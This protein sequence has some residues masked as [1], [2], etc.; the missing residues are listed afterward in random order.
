MTPPARVVPRRGPHF[1]ERRLGLA[2]VAEIKNSGSAEKR[3]ARI[4]DFSI[5]RTYQRTM[6]F[7]GWFR[8]A[9]ARS[10]IRD[11]A[12]EAG[13]AVGPL[14]VRGS[15]DPGSDRLDDIGLVSAHPGRRAP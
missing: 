8:W 9:T 4:R 14:E 11:P 10:I 5:D 15:R 6:V 7:K 2:D 13:A 3:R 1:F 12:D